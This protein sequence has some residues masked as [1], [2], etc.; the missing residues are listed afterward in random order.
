MKEP[1]NNCASRIET[2]YNF[3]VYDIKKSR[4]STDIS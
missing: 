2:R 4:P 1:N 3:M